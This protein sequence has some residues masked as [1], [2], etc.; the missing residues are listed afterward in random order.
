MTKP[1]FECEWDAGP[2]VT[3][4]QMRVVATLTGGA[5]IVRTVRTKA[6]GFV[7]KVDV[8]VVQVTVTVTDD[9]GQF[10]R[11]IP[12]S[13]FQVFEDGKPQTITYFASEDVP[14]ELIVAVDISGSMTPAM[15]KL[16]KAVKEFLGAVPP[17]RSGDAARL[18]RQRSSR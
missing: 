1:P 14:L 2:D 6:L 3:A 9:H 18:Q 10:V 8:D 17:R 4:H 11:D 13:A 12:R 7:E 15:P 16:K 5:R